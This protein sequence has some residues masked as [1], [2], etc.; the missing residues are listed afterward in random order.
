MRILATLLL[1]L[2]MASAQTPLTGLQVIDTMPV[3][4]RFWDQAKDKTLPEQAALFESDVAARYPELYT[5]AVLGLGENKSFH[6]ALAAKYE[7]SATRDRPYTEAM[8]GLSHRLQP[9][10]ERCVESFRRE[11]PDFRYEGR[12]YLLNSLDSFDGAVR[13]VAGQPSLLFGVETIARINRPEADLAPFFH[14]ELFHVYHAQFDSEGRGELYR[15][16]WNEGL[17]VYVS[18]VLNPNAPDEQVFGRPIDMPQRVR[19]VLPELARQFR[20]NMDSTSPTEYARYFSGRPPPA[21]ATPEIPPR[22]GYYL[23]YLVARQLARRHEL[24]SLAHATTASLR[25]EIE[26]A[27]RAIE[28]GRSQ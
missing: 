15:A 23:G 5:A 12:I 18:R 14:H 6:D 16:L 27:L 7:A 10:L 22:T 4:W 2:S 9:L 19:A 8:L 11:F 26:Q 17:A 1:G 25:G 13:P 28:Q 3:Y 21:A 20:E 24:R